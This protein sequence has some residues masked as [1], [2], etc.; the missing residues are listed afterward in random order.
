MRVVARRQGRAAPLSRVSQIAKGTH[1]APSTLR[2]PS[3]G[4]L[5]TQ[6]ITVRSVARSRAFY[7]EVLGDQVVL[8]ENPCTIKLS[9]S[10]VISLHAQSATALQ[11]LAPGRDGSGGAVS[12]PRGLPIKLDAS[13]RR[14]LGGTEDGG[15]GSD[16]GELAGA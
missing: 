5:D 10:W 4:F 1:L 7:S 8:E 11:R 3:E 13:R 14:C 2:L 16:L 6:F 15:L 9:N 12:R